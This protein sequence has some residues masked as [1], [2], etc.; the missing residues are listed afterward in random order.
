MT[1]FGK[2]P[3]PPKPADVRQGGWSNGSILAAATAVARRPEK[4]L[5]LFYYEER[6]NASI[7]AI[8][9]YIRGKPWTFH[10]DEPLLFRNMPDG[11][12]QLVGA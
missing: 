12:F 3:V 9:L 6:N 8:K 4:I 5:D 1:L 11:R 10:I 2:P 7:Y